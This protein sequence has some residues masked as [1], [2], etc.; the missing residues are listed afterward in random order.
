MMSYQVK[1]RAIRVCVCVL[2]ETKF[3]FNRKC[4]REWKWKCVQY[5][6]IQIFISFFVF[7]QQ[8]DTIICYQ[9]CSIAEHN[10]QKSNKLRWIGSYALTHSQLHCK[11][12]EIIQN[13]FYFALNAFTALFSLYVFVMCIRIKYTHRFDGNN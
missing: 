10:S 8:T 4:I 3:K 7:S 9:N 13:N 5:A 6:I 1:C 2:L 12:A 11:R